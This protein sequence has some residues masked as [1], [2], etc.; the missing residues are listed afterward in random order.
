MQLIF[1]LLIFRYNRYPID[2]TNNN[3]IKELL[4]IDHSYRKEDEEVRC[5]Q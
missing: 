4:K 5:M 3:D 2:I 1:R